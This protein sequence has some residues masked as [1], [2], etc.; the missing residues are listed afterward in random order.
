MD[1]L[2]CP[3]KRKRRILWPVNVSLEQYL[4]IVEDLFKRSSNI[5]QEYPPLIPV[6]HWYKTWSAPLNPRAISMWS[7]LEEGLSELNREAAGR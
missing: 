1:C 6:L 7:R 2:V 5:A 3:Q 4:D